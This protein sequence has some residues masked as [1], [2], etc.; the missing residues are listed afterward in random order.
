MTIGILKE[1]TKYVL[2]SLEPRKNKDFKSCRTC[3]GAELHGLIGL[4]GLF[5]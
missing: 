4:V 5:L 2:K 1:Y 3:L